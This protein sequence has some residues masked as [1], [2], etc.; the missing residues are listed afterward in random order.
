MGVQ[1]EQIVYTHADRTRQALK[2]DIHSI[3]SLMRLIHPWDW[4][5]EKV[6]LEALGWRYAYLDGQAL[7]PFVSP[8]P[9]NKGYLACP[10]AWF[11]RLSTAVLEHLEHSV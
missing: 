11:E 5:G 6:I 4:A 2:G 9:T 8:P 7:D 1:E 10:E 3:L